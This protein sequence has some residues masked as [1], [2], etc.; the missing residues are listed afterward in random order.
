MSEWIPVDDD[1]QPRSGRR[2]VVAFFPV[3]CPECR[4]TK[5]RTYGQRGATRYHKCFECGAVFTSQEI[6]SLERLRAWLESEE[7][8]ER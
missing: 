8:P 2:P 6:D 4:S 1:P 3:R 7:S 5:P